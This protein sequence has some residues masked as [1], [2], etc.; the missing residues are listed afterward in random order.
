MKKNKS[1]FIKEKQIAYT[2]N[3]ITIP[4]EVF[5][6]AESKEEIED[7]LLAHDPEFIKR[8]RKAKA[9]MD[10]GKGITLEEVKKK[11]CIK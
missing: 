3:T 6:T 10:A 4:V 5:E 7:W 8:M 9:D 11:L 1:Q 2:G